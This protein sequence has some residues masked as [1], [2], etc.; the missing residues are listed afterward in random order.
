ME[1]AKRQR[2][3]YKLV[4]S[5]FLGVQLMVMGWPARGEAEIAGEV[6]Q[7]PQVTVQVYNDARAAAQT[8]E[9]GEREAARI[10]HEAGVEIVWRNCNPAKKDARM[11]ADCAPQA[12]PLNL[13]LIITPGFPK[14]QGVTT[15]HTM[16]LSF[17][18]LASVSF[19]EI[20]NEAGAVDVT[21]S[22]ILGPAIAHELG[23]VLLESSGHTPAGIMRARWA[24]ED[25]L[26][27]AC[28]RLGFSPQQAERMR[29]LVRNRAERQAAEAV[30]PAMA[31][32]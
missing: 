9:R 14:V 19:L 22:E 29:A 10:F 15:S 2:G 24:H 11:V 6:G 30:T 25:L 20:K 31:S 26:A 7:E 17:G 23:H 16:G 1:K 28:G 12:G 4:V 18:N 27:A 8:L 5:W 21:A 13:G 3:G 32:K